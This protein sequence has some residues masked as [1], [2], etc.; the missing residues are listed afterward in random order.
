MAFRMG[1]GMAD[2]A[3]RVVEL[4]PFTAALFEHEPPLL[5]RSLLS[6]VHFVPS[7]GS[8]CCTRSAR[9]WKTQP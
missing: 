5:D 9:C 2:P 8:G 4:A 6:E 3:E 1:R 7:S